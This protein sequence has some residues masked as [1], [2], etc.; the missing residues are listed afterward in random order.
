MVSKVP[1]RDLASLVEAWNDCM[2]DSA[3]IFVGIIQII[4]QLRFEVNCNRIQCIISFLEPTMSL[5]NV[6][7][8]DDT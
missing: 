7:N 2:A 3:F 4:E 6:N 8:L 5:S 1:E